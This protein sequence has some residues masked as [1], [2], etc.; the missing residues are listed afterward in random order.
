MPSAV[1]L[2]SSPT[3]ALNCLNSPHVVCS[4]A[5]GVWQLGWLGKVGSLSNVRQVGPRSPPAA[6]GT[7]QVGCPTH[8]PG[9]RASTNPPA[10]RAPGRAHTLIDTARPACRLCKL[11][12]G[13]GGQEEEVGFGKPSLTHSLGSGTKASAGPLPRAG[14]QRA[15]EGG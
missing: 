3:P 6:G 12:V 4:S 10:N 9:K 5:Q 11:W 14:R 15:P 13:V 1:G 2:Y 7:S 8:R